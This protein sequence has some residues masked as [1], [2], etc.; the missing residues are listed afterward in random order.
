MPQDPI[1]Q[2]AEEVLALQLRMADIAKQVPMPPEH[3]PDRHH[4][5]YQEFGLSF[6]HALSIVTLTSKPDLNLIPSAFALVRPMYETLQRGWWFALC[7]TDQQASQLVENDK[8]QGGNLTDVAAAI[9]ARP[10]F[11]GTDFFSRF[12]QDEWNL[13]HSFTHGGRAALAMYGHR[14]TLEADFDPSVVLT[15][16]DNAARMSAM[17]TFGMCHVCGV[18]AP[19]E[20]RPLCQELVNM[21]PE[22]GTPLPAEGTSP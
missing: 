3:A 2:R 4:I 10:P 19:N 14:Q 6:Q 13:Y 8:F 5:G 9:D 17:A 1:L 11:V 15:M 18:Y 16:L 21:G 12:S 20:A 7:A 22:L